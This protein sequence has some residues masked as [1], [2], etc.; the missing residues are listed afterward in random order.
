[1]SQNTYEAIIVLDPRGTED[2]I[3]KLIGQLSQTIEAEGA[4]LEQIDN[5]GLK[6]F[7]YTPRKLTEGVYVSFQFALEPTKVDVL[8]GKLKL[9]PNV[10][11]QQY[12][13]RDAK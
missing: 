13:R 7:A 8:R 12:F 3:D 11:L 6:K 2:S 4:R 5:L 1:M 9:H 10:F